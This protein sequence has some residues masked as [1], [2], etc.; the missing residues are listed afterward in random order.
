M[1]FKI[2]FF[3]RSFFSSAFSCI[4]FL[5]PFLPLKRKSLL[6]RLVALLMVEHRVATI[7]F[8][9]SCLL[10]P[11]SAFRCGCVKSGAQSALLFSKIKRFANQGRQKK[12]ERNARGNSGFRFF[13]TFSSRG[14]ESNVNAI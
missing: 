3:P 14:C 7:F 8:L 2:F 4:F 1:F 5:Y 11:S 10:F 6:R 9:G 13:R 12:I